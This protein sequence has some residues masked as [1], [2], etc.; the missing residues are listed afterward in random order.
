MY[1]DAVQAIKTGS[2]KMV[3]SE[4]KNYASFS[5]IMNYLYGNNLFYFSKD[6]KSNGNNSLALCVFLMVNDDVFPNYTQLYQDWVKSRYRKYI[7]LKNDKGIE[8][9]LITPKD[10]YYFVRELFGNWNKAQVFDWKTLEYF[11]TNKNLQNFVY[12]ENY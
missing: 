10:E 11:F 5:N 1:L 4:K 6:M 8:L 3:Q 12:Q 9:Y 7:Y 2:K